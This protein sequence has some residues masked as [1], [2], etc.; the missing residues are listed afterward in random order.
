[1]DD[2]IDY[3]DN[4]SLECLNQNVVNPLEDLVNEVKDEIMEETAEETQPEKPEEDVASGSSSSSSSESKE[5][6]IIQSNAD[7]PQL[8][9]KLPFTQVVRLTQIVLVP[10]ESDFPTIVK[11]F[12]NAP[13]MDFSDVN[14]KKPMQQFELKGVKGEEDVVLHLVS[15]RFSQVNHLVVFMDNPNQPIVKIGGIRLYGTP[16]MAGMSGVL[17]KIKGW[18]P[19]SKKKSINAFIRNNRGKSTL[20]ERKVVDMHDLQVTESLHI[21]SM[22]LS[23]G[24]LIGVPYLDVIV[25][26]GKH[27]EKGIPNIKPA[28]EDWLLRN[29][30]EKLDPEFWGKEVKAPSFLE[31]PQNSGVI[32]V[33]I[34]KK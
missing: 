30:Y 14:D 34:A 25:G 24:S 17:M 23:R 13:H 26:K 6:I 11:L 5:K 15:A 4:A 8:L 20:L 12:I 29:R 22:L 33:Y 27:S 28:V 21:L 18:S 19:F 9:L 2:L 1:M 16:G 7:D 32:R 31:N 10:V 3:I